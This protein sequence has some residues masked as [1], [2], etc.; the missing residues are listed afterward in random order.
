MR[1]QSLPW[2]SW[3]SPRGPL[4]AGCWL[5]LL[6]L[7]LP[8]PIVRAQNGNQPEQPTLTQLLN[9]ASQNVTLLRLRLSER[10]QQVSGLQQ[11]LAEARRRLADSEVS[12]TASA[13]RLAELELQLT[14][15]RLELANSLKALQE[16]RSS[17][18]AWE[19]RYVEL[20]SAWEA[21]RAEMMDQ[22]AEL[23]R[24]GATARWVAFAGWLAAAIAVIIALLT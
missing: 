11:Q 14:T 10:Q 16:T 18:A 20:S 2:P 23:A 9:E 1:D 3:R 7:A 15:L 13:E 17:L 24:R 4:A 12:W 8:A 22:T 19:T 5:A 6:L 21:Y